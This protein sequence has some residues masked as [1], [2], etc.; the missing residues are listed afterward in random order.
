MIAFAKNESDEPERPGGKGDFAHLNPTQQN[1]LI[2]MMLNPRR[3][4]KL[5]KAAKNEA[6]AV[7]LRN[8]DN[9]DA[10]VRNQAVANMLR[11]EAQNQT[12]QHKAVDKHLPDLH[13]VGGVI[14][15]RVT[16]QELLSESKYI[17]YLREC[18]RN[19]DPR[20][21]C[22]NG[23]QGNGKPLDDGSARNGH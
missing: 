20:L 21:I 11:M 23:H 19:S 5:T 9:P 17:E 14:E 15:H 18:E 8:L 12:D 10:R 1:K 13:A 22:Q 7:T 16:V 3:R 6:I 2:A 4:W